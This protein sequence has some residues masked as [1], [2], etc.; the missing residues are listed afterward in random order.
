MVADWGAMVTTQDGRDGTTALAEVRAMRE[1]I[2]Q[3]FS[4]L[5]N[6]LTTL[7]EQVRR[8]N[9]RVDALEGDRDYQRGLAEGERRSHISWRAWAAIVG[10]MGTLAGGVAALITI[11]LG[12]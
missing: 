2:A 8:Q 6:E 9:G 12:G 5:R 11:F 7:T 1:L 3:E 10:A 4:A